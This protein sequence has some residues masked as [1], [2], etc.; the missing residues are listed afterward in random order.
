[1]NKI[2][3]ISPKCTSKSA[4]WLAAALKADY[5]NPYETGVGDFSK[6]THVVNYGYSQPFKFGYLATNK[7][8][9]VSIAVDKLK[10]FQSLNGYCNL[11]VYTIDKSVAASWIEEGHTV[12]ARELKKGKNAKG[13]T[14]VDKL[15]ELDSI[16][17]KFY[18][19]YIDHKAEYRVN[20]FRGKLI[21]VLEKIQG[22]DGL[23]KFKLIRNPKYKFSSFIKAVDKQIGLDLYGMDILLGE[24]GK[25]YFLEV[26]S[27]PSLFGQTS[28]Q[29]LAA[30]KKE[31]NV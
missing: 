31:I 3:V 25:Y 26:N 9:S 24:D 20:V 11:V 12:V 6:Y 16:P 29:M 18:T 30:I 5:V 21:S 13:I 14:F 15:E 10:T 7:Y 23:F 2:C 28:I 4:K 27:G 17:A 8:D 19:K 22:D 1:M